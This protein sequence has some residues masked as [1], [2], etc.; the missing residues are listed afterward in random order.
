[1]IKGLRGPQRQQQETKDRK[2]GGAKHIKLPQQH[3]RPPALPPIPK[4]K[5]PPQINIYLTSVKSTLSIKP[6]KICSYIHF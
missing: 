5:N 1:M 4:E 2:E 3:L 6:I